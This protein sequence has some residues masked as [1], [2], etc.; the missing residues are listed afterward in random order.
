MSLFDGDWSVASQVAVGTRQFS[1][2]KA[3]AAML[4]NIWIVWH[5]DSGIRPRVAL[6][7][8]GSLGAT[9]QRSD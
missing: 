7:T 9:H 6:L 1:A 3:C 5:D 4:Q 8:R 2:R